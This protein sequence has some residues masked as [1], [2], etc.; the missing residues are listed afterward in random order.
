MLQKANNRGQ[1]EEQAINADKN[2]KVVSFDCDGVMFDT[3]NSNKAFYNHILTHFHKPEMTAAQFDYVQMHTGEE[4]VAFLFPD[5]VEC[6]QAQ[7]YRLNIN[8]SR[9]ISDMEIDPDLIPLLKRLKPAFHLTVATNRTNTMDLVVQHFQLESYFDMVVCA[10]HVDRPKPYPDILLL[11]L[12][13]FAIQP[14][15][16]LFIGDS[17]LDEQAANSAG[18]QFVACRNPSLT[19]AEYHIRRLAEIETIVGIHKQPLSV[20]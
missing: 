6:E 16:M 5:A 7:A 9:F 12:D 4:S 3:L 10:H 1:K 18:V 20:P 15:E 14:H 19:S 11:I 8:Y 13:N 17:A 2:I